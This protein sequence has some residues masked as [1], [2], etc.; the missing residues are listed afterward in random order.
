MISALVLG[1]SVLFYVAGEH[2]TAIY[3]AVVACYVSIWE[4]KP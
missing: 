3:S 2:D 4:M 1:V